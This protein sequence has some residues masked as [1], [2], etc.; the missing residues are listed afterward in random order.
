MKPTPETLQASLDQFY[1]TDQWY[2]HGLN[3]NM[4]YTDGVQYFAE[5][6][7]AYWLLDIIATEVFPFQKKEP[8][9]HITAYSREGKGSILVDNGN[10]MHVHYKS[11]DYTDLPEGSWHFYLTDNVLLL[12]SEY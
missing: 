9:L 2:R 4:L 7:G 10:G 1:G 11:I 12:P 8:F 3:P 6:A 5:H